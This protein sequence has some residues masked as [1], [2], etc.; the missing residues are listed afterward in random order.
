[1]VTELLG[2]ELDPDKEDVGHTLQ[3]LGL[4]ITVDNFSASW[5]LGQAKRYQWMAELRN[6]LCS[7]LLEPG[8]AA[9]FCGRFAFLNA[10]LFNR[11]GRALLRP[12]IWRQ[13][14]QYGSHKLTRRLRHALLWFLSVLERGLSRVTPL[15][16]S[17]DLPTV[18]LYTDAENT[19]RFGV[20]A[21]SPDGELVYLKGRIPQRTRSLLSLRK[22]NIVAFEL[23]AALIP[24]LCLQRVLRGHRVVHFID[25]TAALACVIRGFSRK[26]DLAC[27]AGRLWFEACDL[28][29]DYTAQYVPT[30]LNLADGPSRD[31]V[32]LMEALGAVELLSWQFPDFSK[33]LGN[34]MA[35][36]DQVSRLV[37]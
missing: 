1:M 17:L 5:R 10:Y 8:L 4:Q 20:V 14:Q 21:Q 33:G 36:V 35:A 11:L 15:M 3:L 18:L 12:L 28:M 19:A 26:P 31:D 34:W 22:T 9:K 2:W 16:K 27:L 6:V 24:F 29:I 7:N 30:K 37:A 13:K 25:S 32:S 23:I